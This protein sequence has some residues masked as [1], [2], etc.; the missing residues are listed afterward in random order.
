M[1]LPAGSSIWFLDFGRVFFLAVDSD[2]KA[3][4]REVEA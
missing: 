2:V 4:T 1:I 3:F